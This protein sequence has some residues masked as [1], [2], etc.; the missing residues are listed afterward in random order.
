ME[1][2]A[3]RLHDTEA[4]APCNIAQPTDSLSL[5]INAKR[6]A[7]RA[8]HY[9]STLRREPVSGQTLPL[10]TTNT[11]WL[12]QHSLQTPR[13]VGIPEDHGILTNVKPLGQQL[14]AVHLG[15]G[16][17]ISNVSRSNKHITQQAFYIY[18][19][20]CASLHP[21]VFLVFQGF[22]Q[23]ARAL[24][25]SLCAISLGVKLVKLFLCSLTSVF[26]GLHFSQ[27]FVQFYLFGLFLSVCVSKFNVH[28]S[29]SCMLRLHLLGNVTVGVQGTAPHAQR[30]CC[31]GLLLH[32]LRIKFFT[33][34][35]TLELLQDLFRN[36]VP[37]E[38]L[39]PLQEV[40]LRDDILDCDP[41]CVV[42]K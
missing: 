10:P 23:L 40:G 5:R 35:V 7:Y 42:P 19:Q 29:Q 3:G 32:F 25:V 37:L 18:S 39:Q 28:L 2:R 13:T 21:S 26:Q 30:L 4:T 15:K 6:K 14:G 8:F 36:G 17:S 16:A 20:L 11:A 34:N 9:D 31:R 1:L 24:Q 27:N 33:A 22:G 38:I 41:I 12:S